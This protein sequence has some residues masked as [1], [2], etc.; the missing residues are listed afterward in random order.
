M[1]VFDR[2][3][4]FEIWVVLSRNPLRTTLTAFGVFWGVFMLVI[5]MG[6][7]NGLENGVKSDFGSRAT[8]SMFIW[9]NRTTIPYKGFPKNRSFQLENEDVQILKD[10]IPDIGVI[11]PRCQLGGYGSKKDISRNRITGSFGVMGDVPELLKINPLKILKGRFLN[12]NDIAEN[13]K[14]VV[15]G[16]RVERIL[17]EPNENPIGEYIKVAGVYFRIIGVFGNQV[18]TQR[19]ADELTNVYVP[20]SS[21]QQ[22]YNWGNIIGWMSIMSKPGKPMSKIDPQVKKVLAEQHQVSPDDKRAFGS[23]NMEKNFLKMS[24]LFFGIRFLIWIVGSGTLLAGIIGISNIMLVVVK[25]RT[26]EIGVR[27]AIGARPFSIVAQIVSET[28]VLTSIAGYLGLLVS[29]YLL[30]L[31]SWAM[32]EFGAESQMFKNPEVD[33]GVAITATIVIIFAGALAGWL[34]A[35]K[36]ARINPVIALKSEG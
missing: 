33:F 11:A 27:K 20:I 6:S 28:I 12:D 15:I 24:N 31:L 21:F 4:L 25:E 7:G 23:W 9:T 19:N 10:R 14:V 34:P 17:F 22:A 36:A 35:Q 13:R 29:I 3:A 1:G 5:M 16:T 18:E 8:N 30:E 32:K 2:D 26:K